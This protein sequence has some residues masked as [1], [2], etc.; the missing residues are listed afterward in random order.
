MKSS[1]PIETFH[2]NMNKFDMASCALEV[3]DFKRQILYF[4]TTIHATAAKMFLRTE[5]IDI[6]K[7]TDFKAPSGEQFSYHTQND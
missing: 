3:A 2:P 4:E 6:N 5:I 7:I 1:N